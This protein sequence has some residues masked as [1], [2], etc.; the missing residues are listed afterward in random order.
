MGRRKKPI[1]KLQLGIFY[2]IDRRIKSFKILKKVLSR[3]KS[4][5][6]TPENMRTFNVLRVPK[7]N[8]LIVATH[9]KFFG[10]DYSKIMIGN[11]NQDTLIG[12]VLVSELQR[13]VQGKLKWIRVDD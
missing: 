1:R 13:I 8:V 2:F 11:A 12:Y 3:Q 6:F 4:L 5:N 10:K 7:N 9:E